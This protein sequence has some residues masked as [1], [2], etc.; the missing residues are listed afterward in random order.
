PI[1]QSS[2]R[3]VDLN[4]RHPNSAIALVLAFI[5]ATPAEE[6][7]IENRKSKGGGPALQRRE[8]RRAGRGLPPGESQ[9]DPSSRL[10]IFGFRFS[11]SNSPL[12]VGRCRLGIFHGRGPRLARGELRLRPL[13]ALL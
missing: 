4:I 10:S 7:K 1:F 11:S 9:G 13:R 3:S 5:A 2:R 6:P 12:L 8:S